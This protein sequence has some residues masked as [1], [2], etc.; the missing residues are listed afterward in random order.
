MKVIYIIK[1]VDLESENLDP[2]QAQACISSMTYKVHGAKGLF[3]TPL[4][5]RTIHV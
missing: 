3:T 1:N 2:T 4:N 5:V